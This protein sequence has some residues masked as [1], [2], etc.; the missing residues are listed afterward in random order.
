MFPLNAWYAA[1]W[2]AEIGRSL[3][4]RTICGRKIVVYRQEN[5]TPTALADA[6]WHRLVPLSRGRLRGDDVVCGYHGIAYD[7][8]GRCSFMPS[9]E[10]INPSASV[11]AFPAVE[12]HRL[13]W[14]WP[15]DPAAANAD[16][17]PD[18][19]WADDPGWAGD[20]EAIHVHCDYR[21]V[22]DNLMDLTHETFVHSESIGND[23]VA[24]APFSVTHHERSVTVTRWMY[25]ITPPPAWDAELKLRFPDYNGPVDRWQVIRWQAPSTICIDVG[26]AKAST[27]APDGDYS[28]GVR[29]YVLNTITP[30]TPTESAYY[31]L[32]MRSHSLDDD[33]VTVAHR[34][35]VHGIFTQD[36]AM[37]NAQQEAIDAHPGYDF[38]NLNIDA[39]SMWV[40]RVID[41]LVR[42]ESVPDKAAVDA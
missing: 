7:P 20:G 18:M 4:P 28:Q 1:G 31:W 16:Q 41:R 8:Q 27:G 3:T 6:C 35:A 13:I 42:Q 40:R 24:E 26:V 5:G 39:G 14:V 36:E 15:G 22:L 11:Q 23:A 33:A 2:A 37:L 19:H 12:R 21:L 17:V 38:Y 10:T 30:Q 29:G 9:Q 34:K 32:R 25:G